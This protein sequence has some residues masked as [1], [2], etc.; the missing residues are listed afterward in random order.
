MA[1]GRIRIR[2]FGQVLRIARTRRRTWGRISAPLGRLAGRS[3][4]PDEPSWTIEYYDRLEAVLGVMGIEQAK[5]L[6]AMHRIKSVV[7]VE[8]DPLRDLSEGGPVRSTITRPM[9][10]SVRVFAI[11]A[12]KVA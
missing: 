3:T 12:A 6:A 9:A 8:H 4:A 11:C 7:D 1:V 2:V 10:T 5:L